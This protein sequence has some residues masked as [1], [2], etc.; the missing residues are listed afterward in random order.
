M[1]NVL[2]ACSFCGAPQTKV[3]LVTAANKTQICK[4]CIDAFREVFSKFEQ[5]IIYICSFCLEPTDQGI[6]SAE[7]AIICQSCVK[8]A[9]RTINEHNE[10]LETGA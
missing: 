7:K 4:R 9:K 6:G 1:E 10:E 2:L 8:D 5:K 3:K